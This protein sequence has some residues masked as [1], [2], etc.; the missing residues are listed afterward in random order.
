M[1]PCACTSSCQPKSSE[2]AYEPSL[3]LSCTSPEKERGS[4]VVKAQE[5]D[6]PVVGAGQDGGL[7]QEDDAA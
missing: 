4:L 7:I 5:G 6:F 1:S 2:G 3:V